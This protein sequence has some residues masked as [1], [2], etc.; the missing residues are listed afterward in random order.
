MSWSGVLENLLAGFLAP[1]LT[2]LLGYWILKIKWIR[3]R[4]SKIYLEV[5]EDLLF[6]KRQEE[7]EQQEDENTKLVVPGDEKPEIIPS[8]TSKD[9]LADKKGIWDMRTF[10]TVGAEKFRQSQLFEFKVRDRDEKWIF[11][12]DLLRKEFDTDENQLKN[13][14]GGINVYINR[15]AEDGE[16][17]FLRFGRQMLP[18]PVNVKKFLDKRFIIDSTSR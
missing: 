12:V 4:V 1:I 8:V 10:Y 18:E 7:L 9:Y 13:N 2:I 5:Q 17:Y 14:A 6:F 16:Y 11:N 3:E 15:K